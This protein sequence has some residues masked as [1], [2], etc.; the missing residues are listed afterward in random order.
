MIATDLA[1]A[2]LL[3]A[4]PL[5]AWL[6]AL[7]IELLVIIA[8]LAETCTVFFDIADLAYLPALVRK[9]DLVEANSRLEATASGAQVVGPALSGLTIRL[10][11]APAAILVD[12]VSYLASALFLSRIRAAEPPPHRATNAHLMREVVDGL[13]ALWR[14]AVL[15]ALALAMGLLNLGGFIF[16]S[17]YVLY[18]TRELGLDAAA[19]GFVFA[20]GGVGALLG[21]VAAAP[22]RAR[23]GVGRV[24]VGSLVLFGL[25]GM[26]VPLAVL[27]PRYALPLIVASELL[28]WLA[29]IVYQINAVSLRQAVAPAALMGRINGSMRFIT[30]GFRPIGS[31]IGGYLGTRIGLPATLVVGAFGMLI[32]FAPLLASPVL[33]W[34]DIAES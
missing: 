29:L 19:V 10:V 1:R 25:F 17:I 30:W 9:D 26:T 8:F 20:S 23:W 14:N 33:N 11:G 28:Q 32:A 12:A 22:A 7:R 16:L 3:S 4:I 27:F 15:R 5:A 21:S 31:L 18:M 13:A 34:Q 2:A 24:L 6:G